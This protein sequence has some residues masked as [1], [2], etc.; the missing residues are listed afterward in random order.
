M[1]GFSPHCLNHIKENK[2]MHLNTLKRYAR[3]SAKW[4]QA[5]A[6]ND[7][8]IVKVGNRLTG[9]IKAMRRINALE[10]YDSLSSVGNIMRKWGKL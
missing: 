3:K 7:A 6:D 5:S 10:P 9:N 8:D 2:I 1:R 4:I